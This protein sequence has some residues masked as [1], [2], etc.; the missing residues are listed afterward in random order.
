MTTPQY[1]T[2]ISP[3][4]GFADWPAVAYPCAHSRTG[5]RTEVDDT[6]SSDDYLACLDCGA[7]VTPAVA[8]GADCDEIPF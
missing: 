2:L 4:H 5:W 1:P 3:E 8:L 6:G 7:D